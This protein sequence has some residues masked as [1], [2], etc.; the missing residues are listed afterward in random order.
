[1]KRNSILALLLC[2]L[3]VAVGTGCSLQKPGSQPDATKAQKTTKSAQIANPVK[4]YDSLAKAEKVAGFTFTVPEGV[5]LDGADYAQYYWSTINE[6]L[7]EV[8]YGAEG[9][10]VC[11][12]RKAPAS[13]ADD[14]DVDIS[15]DYNVYDTVKEVEFTLEDGREVEVTLKGKD[16]KFYVANWQLKGVKDNG[17]WNYAIGVRGIPEQ[18]LLELV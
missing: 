14:D 8:R 4:T 18:D 12:M 3:F 1:M 15:G 2:V 9:D 17:V 10:E 5:N 6:N 11:Y 13:A 16:K 7:I